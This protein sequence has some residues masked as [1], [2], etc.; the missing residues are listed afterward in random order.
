MAPYIEHLR[1]FRDTLEGIVP[2]WLKGPIGIRYLYGHSVVLDAFGDALISGVQTRFP[3][4][5]SDQ[6][7]PTIGKERRILRGIFESDTNYAARLITWLTE[8]AHRGS[9]RAM[10]VQLYLHYLPNTFPIRLI[11]R[12]G[13]VYEM[14]TDG[15]ITRYVITG[16]DPDVTPERWATWWL[17]YFTDTWG[18]TVSDVEIS[19]IRAIPTAWNAAHAIGNIMVFPTGSEMFDGFAPDTFDSGTAFDGAAGPIYIPVNS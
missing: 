7:L 3:G 1:T 16:W 17:L 11:A 5:Y 9:A 19:D 15:T 8:H 2:A 6:S 13:L 4:Y 12:N 10:L 18:P 14:A